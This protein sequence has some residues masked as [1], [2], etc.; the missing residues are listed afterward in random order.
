MWRNDREIDPVSQLIWSLPKLFL[1][2]VCQIC[3][4]FKYSPLSSDLY[5]FPNTLKSIKWL[6]GQIFQWQWMIEDIFLI[7]SYTSCLNAVFCTPVLTTNGT[8]ADRHTSW[9]HLMSCYVLD[10]NRNNSHE[11]S[12]KILPKRQWFNISGWC[13]ITCI[14]EINYYF[15]NLIL[16]GMSLTNERKMYS[17]F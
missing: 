6:E 4:K 8:H 10:P 1:F 9:V 15:P 12:T 17:R 14:S 5:D 13:Y 7:S 16:P 3:V 2:T 11:Y